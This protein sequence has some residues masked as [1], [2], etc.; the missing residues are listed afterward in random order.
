MHELKR[1]GVVARPTDTIPH[2]GQR[3]P[4]FARAAWI[5]ASASGAR[6]GVSIGFLSA[7]ERG[8]MRS[9]IATLRR[10]ARFYRTNILSFFEAAEE[11][12]HL[13]RRKQRKILETTPGVRMGVASLGAHRH[14]TPIYFASK[15]E[16]AAANPMRTRAKNFCTC[17][18]ASLKSGWARK[19][20]TC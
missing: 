20:I 7:L 6:Y 9:S 4:A 16:G 5:V 14:G 17:C 15:P 2:P 18:A 11:N 19:S 13:V 10:V 3:F 8:Q 12:P 1:Q